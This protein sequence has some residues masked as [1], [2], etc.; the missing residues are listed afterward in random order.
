M[1]TSANLKVKLIPWD[2]PAFLAAFERARTGVEARGLS[3]DGPAGALA[4]QN[5]LR[6]DGYPKAICYC[7]R[8][9]EEALA[10]QA[11]CVVRRDG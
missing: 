8:N 6:A 10:H 7:E 5:A 1:T 3:L 9:V 11:R 4:L 2:D